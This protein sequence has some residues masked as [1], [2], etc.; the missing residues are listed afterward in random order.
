MNQEEIK[1]AGN[2][3]STIAQSEN[4]FESI[5]ESAPDGMVITNQAGQILMANAQTEKL[6]GYAKLELI[7]Q[8]IEILVPSRYRSNHVVERKNYFVN[9]HVRLMGAGIEL[10]GLKK[11]GSEFPIEISLSPLKTQ[12]NVLALAAI[13]DITEKKKI[14]KILIEKNIQLEKANLAKDEFLTHMSHEL[15]TPLNGVI[16]MTQLLMSSQLSDEQ[17]DQLDII[18]E[19]EEHLLSVINQILDFSKI[20]SGKLEIERIDFEIRDLINKIILIYQHKAKEKNVALNCDISADVPKK[21]TADLVK[22]RQ[23][24]ANILDNAVKFTEAGKIEVKINFDKKSKELLIEVT[25]TGIGIPDA[26]R[27]RLFKP[28]S[29]GDNSMTRKYGGTGLGLAISKKLIEVMGGS[30]SVDSLSQGSRF[31][32]TIPLKENTIASTF[33]KAPAELTTTIKNISDNIRILL[34][35]DNKLNQKA[36]QL[37][38]EKNGF[39]VSIA[40]DGMEALQLLKS[41]VF[42]LVLMDCQMP[43]MDGYTTTRTIRR[44]EQGADEHIPIIGVTANAMPDDREKCLAAG[45]DDYISKPYNIVELYKLVNKYISR[46]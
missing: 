35:D 11:D 44:D 36:L 12:N 9:P 23:A 32:F 38:L 17:K 22:I 5:L 46:S 25:D 8:M 2:L 30:I 43:V 20:E 28:F 34:V 7:G 27:A 45:M 29:Q 10:F 14:E 18:S 40:S 31:H 41:T 21:I 26:I 15:R 13:R 39:N 16:S 4:I 42:D 3:L 33:K 19:S 6:F 1:N 37:I 24:L